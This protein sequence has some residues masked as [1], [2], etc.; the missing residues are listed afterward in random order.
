MKQL[1]LIGLAL[2]AAVVLGKFIVGDPGYVIIGY[3]QTTMRTS[4]VVFCVI[5]ALALLVF[6]LVIRFLLWLSRLGSGVRQRREMKKQKQLSKGYLALASGDWREAELLLGRD[7]DDSRVT[8]VRYLAAAEAAHAQDA[9]GRRD[10]YLQRAQQLLPEARHAVEL[11]QAA[12]HVDEGRLDAARAL[13]MDVLDTDSD[14]AEALRLLTRVLRE[15]GDWQRLVD[16]LLP[17]L[18]RSRAFNRF[19]LEELERDA[20]EQR[21]RGASGED[22]EA[23]W[24]AV[25]RDARRVPALVAAYADARAAGGDTSGAEQLVRKAL[26]R[27]WHAELARVYGRIEGANP[28]RQRAVLDSA[29]AG[30]HEEAPETL[31]ALARLDFRAEDWAGARGSLE[32]LLALSPSPA[33]YQLLGATLEQIGDPTGAQ[34]MVQQGLRLAVSGATDA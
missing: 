2:V 22:V 11:K 29:A 16:D 13:L 34:E 9:V 3:G 18:K 14:N 8:P 26:Q 27:G 19:R 10:E 28:G 1:L 12:I 6:Y 32:R 7:D 5:A 17:Q 4:F 31:L 30:G 24:K 21:L 15:Q 20:H 33:A 25:P 23:A